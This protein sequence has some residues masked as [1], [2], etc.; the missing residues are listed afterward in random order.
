MIWPFL[1]ALLFAIFAW[2]S[3]YEMGTNFLDYCFATYLLVVLTA[4]AFGVGLGFASLIGLVVPKHWTGP[5]T[6]QLVSLRGDDDISGN[7]FLGT[8]KYQYY[9]VLLLLQGSWAGVPTRES[10]DCRQRVGLRGEAAGR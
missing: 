5:E 2:R 3:I 8:G 1:F 10:R 4:V 7:F 9:P 6:A